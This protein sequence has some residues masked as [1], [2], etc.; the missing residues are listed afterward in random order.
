M[1]SNL[2]QPG[3]PYPRP[4]ALEAKD[5]GSLSMILEA[6]GHPPRATA[7][8][9]GSDGQGTRLNDRSRGAAIQAERTTAQGPRIWIKPQMQ[10]S[11]DQT[12]EPM[13]LVFVGLGIRTQP[14]D[15]P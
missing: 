1:E 12:G 11:R 6:E 3:V 13:C 2:R 4:V 5:L 7:L 14:H 8:D 9:L 15:P 10:R